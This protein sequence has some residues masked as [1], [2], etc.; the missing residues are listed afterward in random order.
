MNLFDFS[1]QATVQDWHTQ[2]D[3][4]MGGVST[5]Q[6]QHSSEEN[7]ARF[8]GKVSL[9]NDGGFAQIIFDKDIPNLS[10]YDGV[11]LNVKGDGKTYQLRLENN[12]E[13]AAYSQSFAVKDDWHSVHLL[14]AD[15]AASHN[16]EPAPD[17]PG[18]DLSNLETVGILIGDKQEGEF[19]MFIKEMS[20]YKA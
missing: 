10:D 15:F 12:P 7:A 16:G 3:Q 18:L 14:F 19:E 1:K 5:S 17:A 2:N 6:V 20:V 4:V 8:S 9:E 11:E 13:I